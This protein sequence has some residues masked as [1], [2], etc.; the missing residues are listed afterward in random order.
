MLAKRRENGVVLGLIRGLLHILGHQLRIE[1]Q[2]QA[3]A[4]AGL[5]VDGRD[6]GDDGVES[7][8]AL[9]PVDGVVLRRSRQKGRRGRLEAPPR[10]GKISWS[11]I[12]LYK[13]EVHEVILPLL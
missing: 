13:K 2:V 8:L 4:V 12:R 6:G 1:V 11:R 9:D 5:I 3:E 7:V 10:L